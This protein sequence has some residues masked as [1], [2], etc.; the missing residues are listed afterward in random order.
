MGSHGPIYDTLHSVD[1]S[2][3]SSQPTSTALGKDS[4]AELFIYAE[5]DVVF[6]KVLAH[7][8]AL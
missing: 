2:V 8:E 7:Q 6:L 5:E 4:W 3:G 1:T